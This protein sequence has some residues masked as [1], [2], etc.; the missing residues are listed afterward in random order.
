MW[1]WWGHGCLALPAQGHAPGPHV[2]PCW[3]AFWTRPTSNHLGVSFGSH[4]SLPA[5]AT[6]ALAP[7]MPTQ[8]RGTAPPLCPPVAA[9]NNLA[10]LHATVGTHQRQHHLGA[11]LKIHWGPLTP[12][13]WG[14]SLMVPTRALGGAL[15]LAPLLATHWHLPLVHTTGGIQQI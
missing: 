3:Q 2:S 15:P 6:L 14:S 10:L 13:A 4:L 11:S 5:S 8:A 9:C 1:P 12:A 7:T